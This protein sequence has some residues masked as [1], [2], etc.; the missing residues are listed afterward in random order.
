[1]VRTLSQ[2]SR[3]HTL[4]TLRKFDKEDKAELV[5]V[6]TGG[7]T[8]SSKEM[9]QDEMALA[10]ERLDDEQ[11]G[12]IK[13][14]RA[15]IIN[16][17]RDIFELNDRD[18]FEQKHYDALNNFLLKKFKA[19]LHKLDYHQ[20]INAVTSMEKWRESELSKMLNALLNDV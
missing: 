19:Q 2:N 9:T 12:S 6:V 16:V 4:L 17:A 10:I 11:T 7:R 15:K 5:R 3:F 20:L 14:M 1:M 8:T 13:K 18:K